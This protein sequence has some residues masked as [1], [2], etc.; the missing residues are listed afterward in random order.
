VTT[1]SREFSHQDFVLAQEL[2][3][4]SAFAID[5]QRLYE[6]AQR[7]VGLRDDV[8]EVISHDLRSPLNSV[9]LSGDVLTRSS[10]SPDTVKKRAQMILAA[11]AR[12]ER[13]IHDLVDL[14]A[15]RS[16]QL[17]IDRKPTEVGPIVLEVCRACEDSAEKDGIALERVVEPRL[18]RV[19]VDR[20]R[21]LQALENLITNALK[22]SARGDAVTVQA[23]R[24]GKDILFT[25]A[26]TG[27]G[28]PAE[29][30]PRLFDRYFRGK[31]A[32]GTGLGLGLPITRAIV[33]GHGGH[34]WVESTPEKGSTFFFTVPSG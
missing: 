26:D 14:A 2:T 29:D 1:R 6:E 31:G 34:I 25:V 12:M 19:E 13:L 21:I 33:E 5:N 28:I 24:R 10:G 22:V 8:L 32:R 23:S 18:P 7:A 30:V 9:R 17:S 27:V 20:V 11:T 15:I 4:R 3:R 16:G